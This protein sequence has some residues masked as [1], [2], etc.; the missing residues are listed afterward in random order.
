MKNINIVRIAQLSNSVLGFAVIPVDTDQENIWCIRTRHNVPVG[1]VAQRAQRMIIDDPQSVAPKGHNDLPYAY[2]V[3][4]KADG[5]VNVVALHDTKKKLRFRTIAIQGKNFFAL[6]TDGSLITSNQLKEAVRQGRQNLVEFKQLQIKGLTQDS[7]VTTLLA[8]Q[9]E[10]QQ[11]RLLVGVVTEQ[12]QTWLYQGLIGERDTELRLI[13]IEGQ[14]Q[15]V[16][17]LRQSADQSAILMAT[18]NGQVWGTPDQGKL[19]FQFYYGLPQSIHQGNVLGSPG[20]TS[21]L[22]PP[23][24]AS[25]P[26]RA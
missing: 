11:T 16:L 21:D 17:G 15:Q 26:G 23:A 12:T 20:Y 13:P 9:E 7:Y 24:R 22:T 6:T 19:N 18:G 5:Q 1:V 4:L 14:F 10:G 25:Q 3:Q 8:T 2:M